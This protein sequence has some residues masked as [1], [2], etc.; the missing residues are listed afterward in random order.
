[1]TDIDR[2]ARPDLTET[3][4]NFGYIVRLRAIGLQMLW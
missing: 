1:M 4:D 2:T 3:I